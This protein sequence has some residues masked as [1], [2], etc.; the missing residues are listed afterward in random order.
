[1]H[2]CTIPR[3]VPLA[4]SHSLSR[5]KEW[6]ESAPRCG[7]LRVPETSPPT[8]GHGPREHPCSPALDFPSRKIHPDWAAS[9]RR[10]RRGMQEKM[11]R[12]MPSSLFFPA[13][14]LEY[15]FGAREHREL[16]AGRPKAVVTDDDRR[17][18]GQEPCRTSAEQQSLR[19]AAPLRA[20][21]APFLSSLSLG[22]QRKGPVAL[23]GRRNDAGIHLE[24]LSVSSTRIW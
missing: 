19:S 7:A 23:G 3:P 10:R 16:F 4:A 17:P 9:S 8:H 5:D 2:P 24:S 6:A 13:F 1:M 15:P 20:S 11:K 14:P 22:A 21:R 18:S 12:R